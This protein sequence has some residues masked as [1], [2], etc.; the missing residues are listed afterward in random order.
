[1]A[2]TA[3]R[4]NSLAVQGDGDVL[5]GDMDPLCRV[6]A[7]N[8]M[9]YDFVRLSPNGSPDPTFNTGVGFQTIVPGSV[10]AINV[11]PDGKIL[12]GGDFNLVNEVPRLGIARLNSNSTLDTT[13]QINTNGTG[14][15]FSQ[16]V[17]FSNIRT[18]SDGK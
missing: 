16:V 13:F 1:T 6:Y 7:V 8:T 11:Q 12:I 18:Q 15:S 3:V 2:Y 5:I 9:R 10:W 14:N 4:F 17:Y